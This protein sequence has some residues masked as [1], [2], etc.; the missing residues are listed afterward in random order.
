MLVFL[1]IVGLMVLVAAIGWAIELHYRRGGVVPPP[2]T[3]RPAHPLFT[4]GL[5]GAIGAAWHALPAQMIAPVVALLVGM[6]LLGF[7][8]RMRVAAAIGV[9]LLPVLGGLSAMMLRPGCPCVGHGDDPAPGAVAAY[10]IAVFGFA[11]SWLLVDVLAERRRALP[12]RARAVV[13]TTPP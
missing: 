9:A 12:P 5:V 7:A 2:P 11:V 1:G 4:A 6:G 8:R 10:T 3:R 13:K